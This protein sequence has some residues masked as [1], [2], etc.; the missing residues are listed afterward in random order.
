MVAIRRSGL[1]L[2]RRP[3]GV[4][5]I[6]PVILMARSLFTP[7][8]KRATVHAGA[9]FIRAERRRRADHRRKR[10]EIGRDNRAGACSRRRLRNI[11]QSRRT[12]AGGGTSQVRQRRM[13]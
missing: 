1:T 6:L 10:E 3:K 5:Q 11:T 7:R 9:Q 12:L 13:D 4:T 2:P 8:P